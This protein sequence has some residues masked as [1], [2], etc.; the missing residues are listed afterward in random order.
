MGK[1][2]TGILKGVFNSKKKTLPRIYRIW[3]SMKQRCYDKNLDAYKRYGAI[4]ITVSDR[5]LSFDNFYEDMNTDYEIHVKK[6]GDFETSLDRIDNNKGYFKDNCRWATRKEQA[7]NTRKN[8]SKLNINFNGE[9][10]NIVDFCG[11]YKLSFPKTIKAIRIGENPVKII[12][13]KRI[14]G[15]YKVKINELLQ[16]TDKLKILSENQYKILQMRYGL[17]DNIGHTLEEIGKE[18]GVSRESIR[19][20]EKKAFKLLNL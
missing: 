17:I 15:K 3:K 11:R 18:M 6:F 19:L 14:G 5:W 4:G 2:K 16:D 20:I 9:V 13:E 12:N 8:I 1:T 7:N 10:M